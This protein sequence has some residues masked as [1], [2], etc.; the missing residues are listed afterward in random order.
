MVERPKL[1]HEDVSAVVQAAIPP[2]RVPILKR[3][4]WRVIL[5]LLKSPT[6]RAWITRRY[7]S[8]R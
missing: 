1:F 5:W 2:R 7:G 6:G 8:Q 3:L 4:F